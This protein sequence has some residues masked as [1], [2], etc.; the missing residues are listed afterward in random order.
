VQL[1]S[2]VIDKNIAETFINA[3]KTTRSTLHP[4]NTLLYTDRCI[5]I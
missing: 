1:S 3:Y 5:Q 4:Q 2:R